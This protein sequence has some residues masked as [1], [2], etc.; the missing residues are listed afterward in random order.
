MSEHE[1]LGSII[2]MDSEGLGG[3]EKTQTFDVKIFCLCVLLSSMLIYNTHNAI[4]ENSIQQLSLV[5]ELCK[6]IKVSKDTTENRVVQDYFPAFMWLVRDFHLE[7][8]DEV[9]D[10]RYMYM[11]IYIYICM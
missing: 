3:I 8:V 5:T 11:Y 6:K 2:F 1:E 9:S 7:L 10:Y 4:D